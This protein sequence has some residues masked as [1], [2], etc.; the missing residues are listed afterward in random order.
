MKNGLFTVTIALKD[1]YDVMNALKSIFDLVTSGGEFLDIMRKLPKHV[2]VIIDVAMTQSKDLS[3]FISDKLA[4]FCADSVQKLNTDGV[5]DFLVDAQGY[6]EKLYELKDTAMKYLS[7]AASDVGS[8]ADEFLI[9]M[10][11]VDEDFED[12][13]NT[14]EPYLDKVDDIV[15]TISSVLNSNDAGKAVFDVFRPEISKY[16]KIVKEKLATEL[17]TIVDLGENVFENWIVKFEEDIYVAVEKALGSVIENCIEPIDKWFAKNAASKVGDFLADLEDIKE[18]L[19]VDEAIELFE[20]IGETISSMADGIQDTEFGEPMKTIGEMVVDAAETMD[21]INE[22]A[23]DFLETGQTMMDMSEDGGLM[24]EYAEKVSKLIQREVR[25][26]IADIRGDAEDMVAVG[27]DYIR[28]LPDKLEEFAMIGIEKLAVYLFE[29]L[30]PI[31]TPLI[32]MSDVAVRIV[33]LVRDVQDFISRREWLKNQI[34]RLR[35]NLQVLLDVPEELDAYVVDITPHIFEPL[36]LSIDFIDVFEEQKPNLK[37]IG[38]ELPD[39][40]EL[41]QNQDCIPGAACMSDL[42]LEKLKDAF[43]ILGIIGGGLNGLVQ[44]GMNLE[45]LYNSKKAQFMAI[46]KKCENAIMDSYNFFKTIWG[47]VTDFD[48]VDFM[49]RRLQV[50]NEAA[51]VH[52]VSQQSS[53]NSNRR[54]LGNNLFA[55]GVSF[56][57]DKLIEA[58][59]FAAAEIQGA[60]QKIRYV[61]NMANYAFGVIRSTIQPIINNILDLETYFDA[62]LKYLDFLRPVATKV[63]AVTGKILEIHS[64]LDETEK[65]VESV[66]PIID[67]INRFVAS[68]L[69]KYPAL[70]KNFLNNLSNYAVKFKLYA[71]KGEEFITDI[72][73]GVQTFTDLLGGGKFIADLEPIENLHHCSVDT[74]VRLEERSGWLSETSFAFRYPMLSLT[75]TLVTN[76]HTTHLIP[77]LWEDYA[78]RGITWLDD[79]HM[80]LSMQAL[81]DKWGQPSIIVLMPIAQDEVLRI[82]ELYE[83]DGNTPF[84]GSVPDLTLI[85]EQEMVLTSDDSYASPPTPDEYKPSSTEAALNYN[86]FNLKTEADRPESYRRT[87]DESKRQ[88]RLVAFNLGIIKS[89]ME[90]GP[91]IPLTMTSSTSSLIVKPSSLQYIVESQKLYISEHEFEGVSTNEK[92]NC[93]WFEIWP[94]YN[95]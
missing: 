1:G 53:Q 54:Q 76:D 85:H 89:S 16:V 22:M 66:K 71:A 87:S 6:E 34:Y 39:L 64:Y 51:L 31:R 52:H 30:E 75:N 13:L 24:T 49:S 83:S 11:E 29:L 40:I 9:F 73:F 68:K 7:E 59:E 46:L 70:A 67:A 77:G 42:L 17:D 41:V 27:S 37:T 5:R 8:G 65:F 72:A 45:D 94:K 28:G 78:P 82:Y 95:I 3:L 38:E 93:F 23:D 20:T 79:D 25:E 21:N 47:A 63:T 44:Y 57:M 55:Q 91:P 36:Q 86:P 35:D 56:G 43:G 19:H 26:I 48:L 12:I 15:S 14:V 4:T 84:T 33:E 62:G 80:L 74:C 88:N 2:E 69:G 92:P 60:T 58:C 10:E 18:K 90:V 61:S 81:G 32:E 50:R